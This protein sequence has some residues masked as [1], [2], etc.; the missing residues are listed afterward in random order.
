MAERGCGRHARSGKL[1]AE[2]T[3]VLA[4]GAA[5][6][7]GTKGHLG[8]AQLRFAL[9]LNR[10]VRMPLSVTWATRRELIKEED[11]RG[12]IGLTLDLDQVLR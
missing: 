7:L 6:V 2:Y 1:R 5:T 12:Q 4:D 11:V 9:S 3:I 8:I 10:V